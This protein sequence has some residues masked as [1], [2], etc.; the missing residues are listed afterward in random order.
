MLQPFNSIVFLGECMVEHRV[1]GD[2]FFGGDS[3]NTAYYLS[4]LIASQSEKPIQIYYAT[5]IGTDN[6]SEMLKA[7]M[8]QSVMQLDFV[9]RHPTKT[10]GQYWVDVSDS[11]ERSFRFDRQNSAA[12]D[13]FS[14]SRKLLTA[15]ETKQVDAIYL[16]GISLAILDEKQRA[17]LINALHQFKAKGGFIYFDNNYRPALWQSI[18]PIH[19]YFSL[20]ALADIAFLTN[21]DEY[22]VY[23]TQSVSDIID[24]HFKGKSSRQTLVI[25]QGA[26]PC[27]IQEVGKDALL[28]VAAQ[29][30]AQK[31][32][33][34]T[35]A[36]GDSFAAGFLAAMLFGRDTQS[37]AH[38]AHKVAA[39]VIQQHGALIPTHFLPKL[40]NQECLGVDTFY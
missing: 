34:D 26:E 38:F 30:L 32:V 5:A 12:R 9:E 11:G 1:D 29:Q 36:A 22:A 33:V 35:C 37:A 21:D 14:L 13:Y 3:F 24:L 17:V 16:S 25:R 23:G 2:V 31:Q 7:L 10:L 20:M 8:T 40:S 6:Q 28:Y 18:S 27:V 15:L 19:D 39:S 4:Q